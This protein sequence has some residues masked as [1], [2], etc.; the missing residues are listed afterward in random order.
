[1]SEKIYHARIAA[2]S[3]AQCAAVVTFLRSHG[4]DHHATQVDEAMDRMTEIL[5][6]ELG[7]EVLTQAMNWVSEQA[8]ESTNTTPPIS[9]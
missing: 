1:M 9:H 2:L 6:Q 8:W 4:E 5:A 7:M 3:M